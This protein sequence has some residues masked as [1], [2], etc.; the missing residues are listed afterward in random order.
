[1]DDYATGRSLMNFDENKNSARK[2]GSPIRQFADSP[3]RSD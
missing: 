3:I 1:M 2:G